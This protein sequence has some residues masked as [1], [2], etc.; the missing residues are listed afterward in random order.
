MNRIAS[1]T[2][3]AR[4]LPSIHIN[5]HPKKRCT[6]SSIPRDLDRFRTNIRYPLPLASFFGGG[7]SKFHRCISKQHIYHQICHEYHASRTIQEKISTHIVFLRPTFILRRLYLQ[8]I[9][10][11][12]M[13]TA[14]N[15]DNYYECN[16][17]LFDDDL[18]LY[19]KKQWW[20]ARFKC[21]LTGEVVSTLSFEPYRMHFLTHFIDT[22]PLFSSVSLLL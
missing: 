12:D 16:V 5:F 4:Y 8:R 18:R 22:F 13:K 21:P 7:G 15:F 1:T 20:T 6:Y 14:K 11:I 9:P 17:Q 10:N 3:I 2:R 19:Y